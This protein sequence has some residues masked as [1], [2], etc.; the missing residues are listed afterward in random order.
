MAA[1]NIQSAHLDLMR[2][3]NIKTSGPEDPVPE[4]S[5]LLVYSL[6]SLDFPPDFGLLP[7]ILD[8]RS[9]TDLD[10]SL[11]PP[12]SR[13]LTDSILAL[14]LWI[15]GQF[16]QHAQTTPSGNIYIVNSS[17]RLIPNT[18]S[19]F[20]MAVTRTS[21]TILAVGVYPS[22]DD[23]VLRRG[24]WCTDSHHTILD[25]IG[26]GSSGMESKTT[27][28]PFLLQPSSAIAA[29]VVVLKPTVFRLLR[30]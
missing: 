22:M 17:H 5:S 16:I 11:Q 7:S 21:M 30:R 20:F 14:H 6:S 3:D 29:V 26:S 25:R 15:C 23:F 24:D 27:G 10:A 28:Y 1:G 9:D 12:I 18:R 8:P 19:S 2:A 4:R 13:L